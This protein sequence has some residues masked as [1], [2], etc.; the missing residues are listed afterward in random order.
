MTRAMRLMG[1]LPVVLTLPLITPGTG[2]IPTPTTQPVD[3]I[4]TAS[5]VLHG[6]LTNVDENDW[7]LFAYGPTTTYSSATPTVVARRDT[8][9]LTAAATLTGLSPGT[10]YHVRLVTGD[11]D[12][13]TSGSDVTFTT[14][15]VPATSTPGTDVQRPTSGPGSSAPAT[16]EDGVPAP[17]Q[18]V[19]GESVVVGA[20]QGTVR[21][22]APGAQSF[23]PLTR[24]E[25]L[26]VGTLLDAR[27]GTV[28][29]RTATPH[30]SQSVTLRGALFEVRQ[31]ADGSGLTD[32]ILRGG[33]FSACPRRA[34]A[35]AVAAASR[36]PAAQSLWAHD[37][38]GRFRTR[39]RNSVATVRGT[40]WI[41]TDSCAGT[42][43]RV[44]AGA[45][46][47]RDVHRHKTV[48]VRAGQSYLA[49]SSR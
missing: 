17:E 47:V 10:T 28:T 20:D 44:T 18:P 38:G 23:S 26:P 43:T 19:L 34:K 29:L 32:L 9:S 5:A 4:T 45:V 37:K 2:G 22:R 36:A 30:G 1:L 35:A 14:A 11:D 13:R 24:A 49:R 16:T 33:D 8:N 31:A 25:N 21:V 46:A 41:T 12:K 40:T 42:R 3:A 27:A 6:T 7:Y 48:L 39:G 15:G